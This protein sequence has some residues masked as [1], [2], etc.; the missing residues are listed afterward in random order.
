MSNFRKGTSKTIPM[1]KDQYLGKENK[2]APKTDRPRSGFLFPS[3]SLMII[4]KE[5]KSVKDG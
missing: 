3:S 5:S 2:Q 1:G 4:D